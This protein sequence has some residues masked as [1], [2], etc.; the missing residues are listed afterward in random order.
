MHWWF[1]I[2]GNGIRWNET[3]HVE[4]EQFLDPFASRGF[5]SVIWAFLYIT[6][7]YTALHYITLHYTTLHYNNS[8][9]HI[10]ALH[11]ESKKLGHFFTAYNFRNIKQIF[12]RWFFLESSWWV[13]VVILT[14]L[15]NKKWNNNAKRLAE[16][17]WCKK[18]IT[19]SKLVVVNGH[20]HSLDGATIFQSWFK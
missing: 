1:E 20:R 5:V 4:L 3:K 8:A 11:C 14:L 6:L 19:N 16:M 10:T 9:A 2:R 15:I 18:M 12:W 13:N 17:K 7:H